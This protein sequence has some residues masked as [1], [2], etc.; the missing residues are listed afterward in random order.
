MVL[1]VD[2]EAGLGMMRWWGR[3]AGQVGLVWLSVVSRALVEG[4]RRDL[5]QFIE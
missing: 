4:E 2:R 3:R 1:H 5:M